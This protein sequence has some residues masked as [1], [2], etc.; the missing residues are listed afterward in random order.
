MFQYFFECSD[1]IIKGV[2]FSHFDSLHL[3]WLLAFILFA[4]F[5]CYF[6]KKAT[7]EKR[8]KIRFVYAGLLVLD[9]II[10]IA[11]LSAFGNYSVSYFSI[12]A[13]SISF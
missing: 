9:E 7:P 11:G 1:T 8:R 5:S 12:F 6:Y 2:G 4:G 13:A 3:M 10:K